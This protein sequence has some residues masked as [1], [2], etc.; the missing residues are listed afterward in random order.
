MQ[1]FILFMHQ[2]NVI[3]KERTMKKLV[4]VRLA[5]FCLAFCVFTACSDSWESDD[6]MFRLDENGDWVL[7]NTE[8]I[9]KSKFEQMVVGYGWKHVESHEIGED[10][11]CIKKEFYEGLVGGGPSKYFFAQDTFTKFFSYGLLYSCYREKGYF[12]REEDNHVIPEENYPELQIVNVDNRFLYVI[13]IHGS[14][15]LYAMYEKMTEEELR[16]C[17]EVYSKNI[18]HT[19]GSILFKK[20]ENGEWY[21]PGVDSI[22]SEEFEETI[23]NNGWSHI[24]SYKI[25]SDGTC[26]ESEYYKGMIGSSP[27]TYY[28]A[29][30]TVTTYFFYNAIPASC[31]RNQAYFYVEREN[32]VLKENHLPTFMRI[33]YLNDLFFEAIE[34]LGYNDKEGLIF[35]YSIYGKMSPETLN[36]KREEFVTNFDDL[37]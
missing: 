6:K 5:F 32:R 4:L 22:S 25:K 23:V 12:Y 19:R 9:T 13:E 34:Y 29:K 10:G 24:S 26:A 31:Y 30:D 17:R 28:F 15:Y 1:R 27:S 14:K 20:N 2:L 35:G 11:K 36:K 8:T 37:Q 18:E 3:K 7:L 33:I 16:E 21:L